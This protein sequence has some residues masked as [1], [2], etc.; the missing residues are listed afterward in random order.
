MGGFLQLAP[1]GL[2]GIAFNGA[3]LVFSNGSFQFSED[4]HVPSLHS[5]GDIFVNGFALATQDEVTGLFDFL[6]E[7]TVTTFNG[8]QGNVQLTTDDVLRAGAAPIVNAHFGGHITAPTPWDVRA[9]DDTVVT[10]SW[11]HRVIC[12]D[13]V[14]SFMCRHGDIVLTA[15]DISFALTQTGVYG[16]ANTPPLGDTSKRIA[17][18]AFV[19]GS[20][21]DLQTWANDLFET[22]A[23]ALLLNYA[24][25]NSP[26]F[27]GVPTAP[28]ANPGSTTGQ[29]ATT[30]FV[31][32][33]VTA[34][35][36]GVASFNTRTGA[37]VLTLADITGAGG[38]TLVS[39]AFTGNPTAPTPPP[40]D[41]DTSLATTAFVQAA[42]AAVAAGV[43]S[44][45]S[46]TG[47]VTLQLADVTAVGGAPIASPTFTGT[48][49]APTPAPTDNT[50]RLATTQYVT[51]ALAALPAPVTSF[52]SRSGAVSL[53]GADV[54]AAG[55]AL[56]NS[57]TFIGTP[58]APTPTVGDSST[59]LATTAFVMAALAAAGGG[60]TSFNSRSGAVTLSG[61]DITSAGGALIA[62]PTFTGLPAAPTATS[63][64]NSTQLATCAFVQAA[65]AAAPGGVSSFNTRTG[66]ITLN[67]GDIS[68]AGGAL[69]ASPNFTGNP[70]APTPAPGDNDTSLATTAFVAAAI[71][72]GGGV[73]TFNGRAG[74]VT[75]NATDIFNASGA[76]YHQSDTA[77]A[78]TPQT[79]WF[80]SIGGQLYVQYVD[81]ST[82]AK[83]WVVA[84]SPQPI[85]QPPASGSLVLLS[86]AT[87]T[88]AVASLNFF[89]GFDGT[90]DELEL[91]AFDV[92]PTAEAQAWIRCSAD[93]STFDTGANYDWGYAFSSLTGGNT[94]ASQAGGLIGVAFFLGA[95]SIAALVPQYLILKIRR[96]PGPA[97]TSFIFQHSYYTS[98]ASNM[99][100][101][102]GGGSW[103]NAPLLGL[104]FLFQGAPNIA[105]GTFK[106]YGVAK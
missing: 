46:R 83:S 16:L 73:N 71:A 60:V 31:Q 58:A 77:P 34:S 106:L 28:T 69:L 5:D 36:T 24:P 61:T 62:S 15:D 52:N 65:L 42:L 26:N 99:L 12:E 78:G 90:Y 6:L 88:T 64:T 9:N 48:P 80:D 25:L 18:T 79:F 54:S 22:K 23:D 7:H 96:T 14:H 103:R 101:A 17:T 93:G 32:H 95:I 21:S 19:D 10:A 30:A 1:D 13:G 43:A 92:L 40:G 94:T 55:G 49:A 59:K 29:L 47:A 85:V 4:V 45:N 20:I 35:T 91:H 67:S 81:P 51:A 66:A 84:N 75:L 27:T 11:V 8:R 3:A 89:N 56:I 70:T 63:G 44:F 86:S 97:R 82:S 100:V 57:P 50:T 102:A 76:V 33:A 37:V 38:V 41:N 98:T 53:L 104:Q 72:A 2:G 74:A 105:R 87:V 68:A 39:P